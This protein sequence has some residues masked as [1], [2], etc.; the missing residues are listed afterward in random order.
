MNQ[1]K[2]DRT[3]DGLKEAMKI[4]A[5]AFNNSADEA[6]YLR[7]ILPYSKMHRLTF[8][9][10]LLQSMNDGFISKDS[11]DRY[12]VTEKGLEYLILHEIIQA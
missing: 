4:I 1:S 3:S 8:T 9:K 10:Y 12:R 7:D 6:I 11:I 2:P 5:D